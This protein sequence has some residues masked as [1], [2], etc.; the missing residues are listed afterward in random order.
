MRSGCRISSMLM[1]ILLGAS[2]FCQGRESKPGFFDGIWYPSLRL[3]ADMGLSHEMDAIGTGAATYSQ[4]SGRDQ[5]WLT[6]P[7]RRYADPGFGGVIHAG[8]ES[9]FLSLWHE[10]GLVGGEAYAVGG[11]FAGRNVQQYVIGAGLGCT[12]FWVGKTLFEFGYSGAVGEIALPAAFHGG[13]TAASYD[14]KDGKAGGFYFATELGLECPTIIVPG[15]SAFIFY[16][17]FESV[18]AAAL[19]GDSIHDYGYWLVRN[20]LRAGLSYR[21][22]PSHAISGF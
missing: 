21:I 13:S 10:K 9:E 5:E 12:L 17:F 18:A 4:D 11:Y 1:M 7:L 6:L 8:I 20:S 19:P 15:L 14:F 16:R 2:G 22:G 3:G